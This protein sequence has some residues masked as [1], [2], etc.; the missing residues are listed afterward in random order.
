MLRM[1]EA[2]KHVCL[3]RTASKQVAVTKPL[4][5]LALPAADMTHAAEDGSI[6]S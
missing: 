5:T 1:S 2:R 4:T 3:R 6:L